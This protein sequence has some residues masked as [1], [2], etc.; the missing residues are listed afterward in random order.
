MIG[1][2]SVPLG[3]DSEEQGS[4]MGRNVIYLNSKSHRMGVPGLGSDAGDTGPLTGPGV[5]TIR[6]KA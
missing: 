5:A 4:H 1:L 6:E 2:E 3:G